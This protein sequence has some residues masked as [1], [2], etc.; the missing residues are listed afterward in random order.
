MRLYVIRHADPDYP[1]NTITAFGHKEAEALSHRMEA[2]RPDRIHSSPIPRAYITAEYTA[3]RLGMEIHTEPWTRE[4]DWVLEHPSQGRTSVWDVHGEYLRG[5]DPA[6]LT[7]EAWDRSPHLQG[8]ELRPAFEKL[9]E[10]SDEF[11]ERLGYKREGTLY[12]PVRPNRDK[13]ALFCHNGFG[14]AFLAHLLHIPIPLMWSGFWLPPTSVTTILLDE[15][16]QDWAVPRCIGMGDVS[17]LHAAGLP[18][19]PAGL[20]ANVD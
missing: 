7:H 15:R 12:R 11:L 2:L 1:N 14:L 4:L 6:H 17:H 3:K 19:Q 9:Q 16:T 8:R 13:V 20:K 18:V 5:G 10:E